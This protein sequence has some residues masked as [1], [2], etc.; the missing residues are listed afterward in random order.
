[1]TNDFVR[2][3][4]TKIAADFFL[5]KVIVVSGPRQVGKTTLIRKL[6]SNQKSV[7]YLNADESSDNSK[8]SEQNFESLDSLFKDSKF[9]FIDE[10]QKV[11]GIGNTLKILVDRY[12]DTKQVIATGSSSINLLSNTQEALTGRKFVYEL[13]PLSIRE[14][15]TDLNLL[16][17]DKILDDV[18]IYGTYPD[19][20]KAGT[21]QKIRILTELSSSYLYQDILELEQ[22]RNP[23]VLSK[24]LTALALQLGSEVSLNE[25]SNLTG[26]DLKTIERYI[27]LLEKNYVIFRLPPYYTNQRKTLSKLNKIYFNDLGVRNAL[28]NNFNPLNLR[29]D[30]GALWENYLVLE[31]MKLRSYQRIYANQYFWRTYGGAEIDLVEER[32]GL[33]YGYEFKWGNRKTSPKSW[34]E[35]PN[36][37]FKLINRENFVDFLTI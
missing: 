13:Y 34:L 19:V 8:L 36:S 18:L 22:V 28:I 6:L 32:E 7:A 9:I 17:M 20:Y 12:K 26:L 35:Y 24:L 27:D 1:M 4:E 5:G 33:L 25:L 37:K 16:K 10:A 29:N 11:K 15:N 14:I 2:E 23:S 30:V 31:R 3:I 21:D